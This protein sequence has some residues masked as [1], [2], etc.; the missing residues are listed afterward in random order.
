M[1]SRLFS[2][3]K[4]SSFSKYHIG[5]DNTQYQCRVYEKNAK[6]LNQRVMVKLER[7]AVLVNL[8]AEKV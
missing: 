7:K 2:T 1:M 5:E 8:K 4:N 6:T 3:M